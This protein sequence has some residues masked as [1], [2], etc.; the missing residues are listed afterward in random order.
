M[1]HVAYYSLVPLCINYKAKEQQYQKEISQIF[2][3]D[4]PSIR[5]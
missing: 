1:L 4:L 3:L 5:P 2:E